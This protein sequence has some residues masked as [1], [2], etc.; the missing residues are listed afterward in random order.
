LIIVKC[1]K[2]RYSIK[3]KKNHGVQQRLKLQPSFL[4]D[5]IEKIMKPYSVAAQ[6]Y[7]S[8]KRIRQYKEVY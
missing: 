3:N 6:V 8:F 7:G 5:V 4:R 1:H 2:R